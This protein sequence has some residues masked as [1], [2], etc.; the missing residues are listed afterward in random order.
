MTLGAD[1]TFGRSLSAPVILWIN[2]FSWVDAPSVVK[3]GGWRLRDPFTSSSLHQARRTISNYCPNFSMLLGLHFPSDFS[4]TIAPGPVSCLG[5][6]YS[7]DCT[8]NALQ[9]LASLCLSCP[10]WYL[11]QLTGS[12]KTTW[13]SCPSDLS[14]TV[15]CLPAT[16]PAKDRFPPHNT[17]MASF[18]PTPPAPCLIQIS[19]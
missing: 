1:C 15:Y 11:T 3:W 8:Q 17:C 10:V 7:K 12:W 13:H 19:I 6:F 14:H 16:V 2:G 4:L 9:V 18:P 5:F